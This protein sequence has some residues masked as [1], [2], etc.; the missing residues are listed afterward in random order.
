M[1]KRFTVQ[2]LS[3]L[4]NILQ[5]K[6]KSILAIGNAITDIPV[7]LPDDSLLKELDFTLGSMN[8]VDANKAAQ[9]WEK[10]RG[11]DMKYIQGGSAAN[12]IVVA[13]QLGMKCGFVGKIGD[14]PVGEVFR[15]GMEDEGVECSL[16]KGTQPSGRAVAFITPPNGERTFATYLG[17]ALEQHP[18]ELDERMFEGYDY[19]HVE[20]YLMQCPGVV[21]KAVEIAKGKD[22]TI[23]F[24][25]GSCGI[26]KRY[27]ET[28]SRMVAEYS[29]IVFANELE[30]LEFVSSAGIDSRSDSWAVD[31]LEYI[32]GQMKKGGNEAPVA[33]VKLGAQGSLVTDG[34]D[35]YRVDALPVEVIDTTGAGDAY[36]AGFLYAHSKGADL[37]G[38]GKG[39]ALLASRV[40]SQLGPKIPAA[41]IVSLKAGF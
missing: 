31:A 29:D 22:M 8:H 20:G 7:C 3:K 34:N 27:R 28:V 40:V 37:Q 6:M 36:A 15:K 32:H 2:K 23:S 10:I 19:F 21:E 24:D 13:A 39:G 12:T 38:C 35:V 25:M 11:C 5:Q 18:S 26:V 41:N 9:V 17:A 1:V 14:D 33:V 30:A 4:S 16:F